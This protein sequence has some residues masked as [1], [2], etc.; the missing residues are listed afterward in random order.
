MDFYN[1]IDPY[2]ADW[3]EN[4]ILAG[5]LPEGKVDRRSIRDITAGELEAWSRA[6]FFAGIG[7]WPLALRLAGWPATKPV[8]TGSC[9]CQSFSAAG[10]QAGLDDPRNLWPPWFAQIRERRPDTIFGEQ[11]S[12][13]IGFGWLDG[14][15]RDLEG[16]GYT[17]GACVLGAFSVGAPH[18]RKRL[19]WVAFTRQ[20]SE[21]R[22]L[23]RSGEGH[24]ANG[25]WASGEPRGSGGTGRMGQSFNAR[26]EGHAGN[27]DG[28]SQSGRIGT[29]P[30]GSASTASGDGERVGDSTRG[31]FGIDGSPSGESR[32]ADKPD[33]I[34]GWLEHTSEFGGV[35]S[36]EGGSGEEAERREYDTGRLADAEH[37]GGRLDESR[38]GPQ[39]RE[40]NFWSDYDLVPCSD[41]KA[42]RVISRAQLLDDGFP[43]DLAV[44][45]PSGSF[46]QR[47]NILRGI[48]NAI[49]PQVAAEFIRAYME[50]RNAEK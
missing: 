17:V 23:F 14:I 46:P 19:Y 3:L 10:D 45:C 30:A 20:Q 31:R 34:D 2:A 4:L 7:G 25:S 9:P 22:Q 6:H 29:E 33:A 11:V 26:L 13:A 47:S 5:H 24:S 39:G 44:L 21:G 43:P 36:T 8:W 50:L 37:D 48:G 28:G 32:H 40:V 38:R 41:G 16:E 42:R 27:G 1:E 15:S 35:R 12:N 18:I 49:V